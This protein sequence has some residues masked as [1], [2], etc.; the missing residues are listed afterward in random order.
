MRLLRLLGGA[1]ITEE[2]ILNGALD[3]IRTGGW[4]PNGNGKGP[5]GIRAAIFDAWTEL[6]GDYPS[7]VPIVQ[8]VLL[9]VSSA[10]YGPRRVGGIN[11]W[12]YKKGRTQEDVIAVL[13]K[14]IDGWRA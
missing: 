2:Q 14:A 11:E 5:R 9:R 7:E 12:E 3:L 4:E 8:A 10:I 13:L 1:V 6:G